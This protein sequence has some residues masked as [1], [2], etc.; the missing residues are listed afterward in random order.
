MGIDKKNWT[1]RNSINYTQ[2]NFVN[3]LNTTHSVISAYKSGKTFMST[4]FMVER[5]K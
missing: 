4:I 5:A 3:K 1:C 2:D